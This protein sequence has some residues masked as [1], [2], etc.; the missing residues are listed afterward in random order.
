M[1]YQKL[2]NQ[3]AQWKWH[4]LMRK[5]RNGEHISRYEE[6]SR[7]EAI[8]IELIGYQNNAK[9][10]ESWIKA[11]LSPDLYIKLD[12]AIR[13]RRK[14]Y[15]NAEHEHTRKKSIDLDYEVWARLAQCAQN[16]KLTLS[17]TILFMIEEQER[18]ARYQSQVHA[19]RESLQDLLD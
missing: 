19:V 8:V 13:A 17:E 5:H 2:E 6:Q 11:H 18:K 4:Y 15:F 10:T 3:E 14:R 1:K 16:M 9:A 12:Q 7:H